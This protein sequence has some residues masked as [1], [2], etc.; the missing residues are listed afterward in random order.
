MISAKANNTRIADHGR[1]GA[2]VRVFVC[3]HIWQIC[4]AF[5]PVHSKD[6]KLSAIIPAGIDFFEGSIRIL[7]RQ[8]QEEISVGSTWSLGKYKGHKSL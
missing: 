5:Q 6:A 3:A 8:G 4:Q 7:L 2:A 1:G